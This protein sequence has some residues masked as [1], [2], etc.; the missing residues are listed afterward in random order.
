MGAEVIAM[1]TQVGPATPTI[2]MGLSAFVLQDAETQH[3]TLF[4]K[5]AMMEI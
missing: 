2:Q 1:Y 5:V 4:M 3:L